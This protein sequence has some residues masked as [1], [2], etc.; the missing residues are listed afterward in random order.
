MLQKHGQKMKEILFSRNFFIFLFFP[1][2]Q[3][4]SDDLILFY[5][6][7][8]K[9]GHFSNFASYPIVIGSQTFFCNEQFIMW[10]KAILFGDLECSQKILKSKS[11]LDIKKLGRSVKHFDQKT[12][13]RNVNKIADECNFAKFTQ[14]PTL[15][16]LLLDTGS[17]LIAEA[18]PFDTIWGIGV[19]VE[20]GKDIKQWR[21]LNVLGNSLMR[22]RGKLLA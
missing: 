9:H 13:D 21:G 15:K 22:I 3:K 12:W 4:M 16:N 11:P 19:D 18:S 2:E 20:M 6:V 5:A 10:S 14:H 7:S 8:K 17:S 1:K